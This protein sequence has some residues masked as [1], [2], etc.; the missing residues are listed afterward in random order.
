MAVDSVTEP[1]PYQSGWSI[2]KTVA[3]DP[4]HIKSFEE[5][6]PEVASGYQEAATKKREQDWVDTLKNK[7]PVTIIKE[8]LKDAFKRKRV[9]DR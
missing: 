5:A 7:Y 2:I 8:A 9:E 3:K 4:P 6:T 1:F